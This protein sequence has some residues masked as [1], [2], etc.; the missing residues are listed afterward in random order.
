MIVKRTLGALAAALG[1]A[2]LAAAPAAPAGRHAEIVGGSA[3]PPGAWPSIAYLRGSYHDRKGREHEFACTGSVVAPE[4]IVTAAHCTFGSRGRSP[5]R[6]VA[7]LGVTDHTDPAGERMAIDRFVP[8]PSYE[9]HG[10][11]GDAGLVHL[12]HPTSRPPIP[13]ATTKA[14][15]AKRYSSPRGVPNSAGWGAIDQNGMHLVTQLQEAY[16]RVRTPG[17]CGSLISGFDAD[18]QTCAGTTGAAGAC[19]GDSGGPLVEIDR[20]T[21][22]P[23]LW[24][25]TSYAPERPVEVAPC[26]LELPA[27]YTWMPAYARF[28]QSTIAKPATESGSPP[29]TGSAPVPAVGRP[30]DPAARA[31]AAACRKARAAVAAA[32]RHERAAQRRWRAARRH[33]TGA[34]ARRRIRLARQRYRA[35]QARRRRAVATAARRCRAPALA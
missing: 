22:D 21:G 1:C 34:A 12:T 9:P 7:T 31:R 5:E 19:L 29:A 35:A 23:A 25:V 15:A 18:T 27:V 10:A 6:M 4:W 24:G 30:G 26:S 8:D 3:A 17:E 14:V 16:L 2:V 28:V 32:R 13:L 33:R 11:G 20:T